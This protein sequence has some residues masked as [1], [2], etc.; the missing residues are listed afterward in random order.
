M[1]QGRGRRGDDWG[2]HQ[3]LKGK[4][5]KMRKNSVIGG[6]FAPHPGQF[7]ATPLGCPALLNLTQVT[8]YFIL[9]HD[10]KPNKTFIF[11][12][13]FYQ[14]SLDSFSIFN[15]FGI[16]NKNNQAVSDFAWGHKSP[17]LNMKA[18]SRRKREKFMSQNCQT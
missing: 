11:F 17:K 2:E 13:I 4:N 5:K 3:N 1:P 8:Y 9:E 14:D 7:L 18:Q 15:H 12:C 6:G 10:L 16:S